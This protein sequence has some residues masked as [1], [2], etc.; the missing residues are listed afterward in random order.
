[1]KKTLKILL[2]VVVL[3]GGAVVVNEFVDRNAV[4]A[5][6]DPGTGR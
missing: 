6:E 1:M 4:E 5:K 3:L 2:A